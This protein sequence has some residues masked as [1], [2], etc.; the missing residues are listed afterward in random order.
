MQNILLGLLGTVYVVVAI[1]MCWQESKNRKINFF[2]AV[3][4]CIIITPFF[5]YFLFDFFPTRNPKG[6]VWCGNKKNEAEY[7]GLCGKNKNGE[8]HAN[9]TK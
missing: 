1:L 7:C 8:L 6:C 2:L 4:L 5:A 9:F 3:L